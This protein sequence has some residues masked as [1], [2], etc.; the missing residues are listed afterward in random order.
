[1]KMFLILSLTLISSLSFAQFS[2]GRA[3]PGQGGGNHSPQRPFPPVKASCDFIL[4]DSH[5]RIMGKKKQSIQ[6]YRLDKPTLETYSFGDYSLTFFI[7][8]TQKEAKNYVVGYELLENGKSLLKTE[9]KMIVENRDAFHLSVETKIEN[10]IK[11]SINCIS[12]K[13]K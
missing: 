9:N 12:T 1:M 13:Q 8:Q 6:G 11:L 7:L 4:K 3:I 2:G 5:N 10:N